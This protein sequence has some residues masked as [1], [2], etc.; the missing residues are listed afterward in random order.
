[1]DS[2]Y[3]RL[4]IER[5][6]DLEV[7][8]R[9][10]YYSAPGSQEDESN[11]Q[12]F[13]DGNAEDQD[14]EEELRTVLMRPPVH[15]GRERKGAGQDNALPFILITP[16]A[17]EAERLATASSRRAGKDGDVTVSF[18][19][20]MPSAPSVPTYLESCEDVPEQSAA[21]PLKKP[22]QTSPPEDV[23]ITIE[24]P[25]RKSKVASSSRRFLT[26]KEKEDKAFKINKSKSTSS[27]LNFFGG[28][29]DSRRDSGDAAE[30]SRQGSGSAAQ[31]GAQPRRNS[32][33]VRFQ[34]EKWRRCEI[35]S[36]EHTDK[37]HK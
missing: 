15:R 4:L 23:S 32:R 9:R 16:E 14:N 11:D 10:R 33:E 7:L 19:M 17:R 1:M 8:L 25:P 26:T 35:I 12:V 24:I 5:P 31:S 37:R 18:T 28:S 36:S 3:K 6:E 29:S 27:I 2:L 34:T 21:R 30:E 13:D 20:K 22:Q